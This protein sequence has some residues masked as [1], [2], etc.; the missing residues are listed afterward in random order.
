MSQ[1]NQATEQKY[2][3]FT[4]ENT[5]EYG[6]DYILLIGVVVLFLAEKIWKLIRG[7]FKV[8]HS[9]EDRMRE[10]AKEEVKLHSLEKKPMMSNMELEIG[11]IKNCMEKLANKI[12]SKGDKT[13]I[14]L[15][16]IAISIDK[17]TE[18]FYKMDVRLAR[19]EENQKEK[20]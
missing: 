16:K 4:Q 19:V 18:A 11:N 17:Q 10:I 13:D 2:D 15:E 12:E 5:M 3:T 20:K 14:V 9:A 6:M 8:E 1:Y 7:V